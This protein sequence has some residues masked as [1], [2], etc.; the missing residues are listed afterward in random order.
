MGVGGGAR[1][2][3][4]RCAAP[5][6]ARGRGQEHATARRARSC[7]PHA[8]LFE[9]QVT[10]QRITSLENQCRTGAVYCQLV[11]AARPGSV[12]MNKVNL[13]ADDNNALSNYKAL[14]SALSRLG[15]EE[16]RSMDIL[17]LAA[18]QPQATLEL[19]QTLHAVFVSDDGT[20]PAR[21]G[22]LV[23][24]DA[25]ALEG[26]L[27]ARKRKA[28]LPQA[29][30]KVR[31]TDKT[32][33]QTE[34]AD[35]GPPDPPPGPPPTVVMEGVEAGSVSILKDELEYTQALLMQS[36]AESKNLR[37]EVNF[38]YRKLER[39]E[40]ACSCGSPLKASTAVLEILYEKE[41]VQP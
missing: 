21:G 29:Q 4:L 26:G 37:E 12:E 9:L 39:I 24:L 19:L 10:G 28:A 1:R 23:A 30:R 35:V 7:M 8:A 41:S 11:E 14:E 27:S 33:E 5:N 16:A 17:K 32:D 25:N 40:D 22:R 6:A 2:P 15:I 36:R 18:G 31:L 34:A 13:K 20:E 38:Y 3:G